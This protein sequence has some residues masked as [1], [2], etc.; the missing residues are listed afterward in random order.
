MDTRHILR[1][2]LVGTL[3]GASAP[4]AAGGDDDV[5]VTSHLANTGVLPF[6]TAEARWRDKGDSTDF[7]VEIEDAPAGSY[8]LHVDGVFEGTI[9]VGALGQGE[10]EFEAPLDPPKPLFDFDPFGAL[11]EVF[12][13]GVAI[14][15]DVFPSGGGAP[16]PGGG[17]GGPGGGTGGSSEI[18]LFMSPSGIDLDA[19]GRL[20]HREK[21]GVTRFD[22]EFERLDA[23]AYALRVG[24]LEVAT[25]DATGAEQ[26]EIELEFRDPPE[27]GHLPLT[28]PVL[29]LL[30]ELVRGDGA[31]VLSAVMPGEPSETGVKPPKSPKKVTRDVGGR[32]RD[33][34]ESVWPNIGTIAGAS[35]ELA[36]E[37][38]GDGLRLDVSAQGLAS[39][40]YT[41]LVGS[42]V[43][44]VVAVGADGELALTFAEA[45][46]TDEQLL[47]FDVRGE[48]VELRRGTDAA[49]G[50]AHPLSLQH[51]LDRFV[52]DQTSDKRVRRNLVSTGRDLD[53]RGVVVRRVTKS[54]TTLTL[55]M[56]DL[57][58][59]T[60]R[61]FVG[62]IEV[63]TFDVAKAGARSALRL[64]TSPKAKQTLLP[65]D[66]VGVVVE[67]RDA[68]GAP[69]LVAQ[70][71]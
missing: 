44:A 14:F 30:V 22:A 53:A 64:S 43:R 8:A 49:L 5:I 13:G 48:V 50:L 42:V 18:E 67:V 65:V 33:A 58:V 45:P 17:P 10:V 36:L 6:A 35:G 69:L 24:G 11:V 51:A 66:P 2:L 19:K 31:S 54:A 28:F 27:P 38:E 56:R 26:E 60:H 16:G 7:Q 21:Q 46:T 57:P 20:R 12:D 39:G 62:D 15:S 32:K 4:S 59:G 23:G 29:G 9:V 71:P 3:L 41:L 55:K 63:T 61:V 40:E 25:F 37:V 1:G 68:L 52:G 47:D 34:M 70:L